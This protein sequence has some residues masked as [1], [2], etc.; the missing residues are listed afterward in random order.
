VISATL[1]KNVYVL[2]P[3]VD[4]D[5]FS[6]YNGCRRR[7]FLPALQFRD[8]GGRLSWTAEFLASPAPVFLGQP[9]FWSSRAP[10]FLDG[11]R[12]G[13]FSFRR[14]SFPAVFLRKPSS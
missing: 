8:P 3:V 1:I 11:R 9:R 12:P 7:F 2:R 6:V 13:L 4:E 5:G 10:S 14:S